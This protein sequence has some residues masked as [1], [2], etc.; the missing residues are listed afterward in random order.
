MLLLLPHS[1]QALQRYS[2][3][4]A[5]LSSRIQVNKNDTK[6]RWKWP[7]SIKENE[8]LIEK[9]ERYKATFTLALGNINLKVATNHTYFRLI[10]FRNNNRTQLK[11][12]TDDVGKLA[13]DFKRQEDAADH[14]RIITKRQQ[15]ID[16]LKVCDP[17]TNHVEARNRHE[18]GTG[19]WFISSSE[20]TKWR[21]GQIRSSWLQGIPG[22]GK[23]ILCSTVIDE[24]ER[25]CATRS[26]Y[27][28][29]YF[30]FEF[31]DKKKQIVDC[32]LRS[33]IA[34]LLLNRSST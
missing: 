20:F 19:I 16:W 29:A 15:I 22:A 31:S 32:F 18:P 5:D 12:I 30:Y 33:M 28:F 21:D 14:Q 9:S 13:L 6:K 23:T 8:E 34:Q 3:F 2:Q 7:L 10:I 24:I 1:L 26:E 27:C 17:S 11:Q 4:L 25:F